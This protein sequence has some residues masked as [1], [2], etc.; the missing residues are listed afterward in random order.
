MS[1]NDNIKKRKVSVEHGVWPDFTN[2]FSDFVSDPKW[3][4]IIQDKKELLDKLIDFIEKD[5]KKYNGYYHVLPSKHLGKLFCVIFILFL[6]SNTSDECF[7]SNF[8]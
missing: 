4:S 5:Y 7:N 8:I 1:L 6:L 2:N 3:K